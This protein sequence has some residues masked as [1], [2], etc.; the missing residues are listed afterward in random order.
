M[1]LVVCT[2]NKYNILWFDFYYEIIYIYILYQHIILFRLLLVLPTCQ[3]CILKIL[4]IIR[5]IRILYVYSIIK[6]LK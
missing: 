5:S 2:K 6:S 1:M 3:Y 4:S